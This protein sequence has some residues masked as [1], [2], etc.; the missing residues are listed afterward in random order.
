[1]KLKANVNKTITTTIEDAAYSGFDKT[2]KSSCPL[3]MRSIGKISMGITQRSARS[4]PGENTVL[5]VG[6]A[7]RCAHAE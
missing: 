1:M 3:R 4:S 2:V 6:G 5:G 7:Q